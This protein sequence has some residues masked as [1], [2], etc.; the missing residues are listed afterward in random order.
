MWV[1]P[2]EGPLIALHQD[3]DMAE[4]TILPRIFM[5]TRRD[6]IERLVRLPDCQMRLFA[7]YSG[8]GTATIGQRS[9]S[10]RMDGDRSRTITHFRRC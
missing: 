4:E 2:V 10:W 9:R 8:W 6:T 1:G 7:G 5:S 3:R